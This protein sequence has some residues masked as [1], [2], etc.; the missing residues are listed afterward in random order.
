MFPNSFS[1]PGPNFTVTLP[2]V[3]SMKA[4][5]HLQME[6]HHTYN[7]GM[8]NAAV[9]L[10]KTLLCLSIAVLPVQRPHHSW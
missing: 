1:K 3:I 2:P 6:E 9:Y 5:K 8:C 4:H 10:M 7:F